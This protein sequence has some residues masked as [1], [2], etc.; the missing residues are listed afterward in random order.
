ME[1]EMYHLIKLNTSGLVGLPQEN[2]HAEKIY[3]RSEDIM[4]ATTIT[5]LQ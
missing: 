1:G 5:F 3:Y 2:V 4:S